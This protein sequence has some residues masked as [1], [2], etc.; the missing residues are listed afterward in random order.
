MNKKKFNLKYS[1]VLFV[2]FVITFL[3]HEFGHWLFG[4]VTGNKMIMTLN[5][6]YA[7]DIK[8]NSIFAE[9]FMKSGGPIFT[10]LQSIIFLY[11]IKYITANYYFYAFVFAPILM[12]V[13]TVLLSF[14]TPQDEAQISN[15]LGI[16]TFTLPVIIALLLLYI[17]YL[18]S[19]QLDIKWKFNLMNILYGCFFIIVIY[20]IDDRIQIVL[21]NTQ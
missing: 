10:I 3:F 14:V 15:F 5:M 18:C 13:L 21:K 19:I 6:T 20:F 4:T 2:A 8:Y 16:G 17:G 9:Y 11:L 7:V 12:R 1:V